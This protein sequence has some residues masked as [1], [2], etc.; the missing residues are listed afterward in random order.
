MNEFFTAEKLAKLTK[1]EMKYFRIMRAKSGVLF[2]KSKPGLAKSAIVKSIA[3]K[4]DMNFIDLRV[5]MMDEV[6]VGL[7][8]HVTD[9]EFQKQLANGELSTEKAMIKLL[10]FIVPKW[11]WK[12]NQRPTI[13]FFDEFNRGNL[14]VR[15]ACM[16]ILLERTIGS[17]FAFNRGVLMCTAGNM[18]DED[19]TQTEEF[20]SALNNRLIHVNHDLSPREWLEDFAYANVVSHI[21]EYIES[22]PDRLYPIS[23]KN[24]ENKGGDGKQS[25]DAHATPRSWT[26]LSDYIIENYGKEATLEQVTEA[27]T[28]VGPYY[29]GSSAHM[30]LQYL[31]DKAKLGIQDVLSNFPKIRKTLEA[32]YK[33]DKISQLVTDLKKIELESLKPKEVDNLIAFLEFMKGDDERQGFLMDGVVDKLPVNIKKA[34]L[35]EQDKYKNTHRISEH[36]KPLI[37]KALLSMQRASISN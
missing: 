33:R 8:P 3:T 17:E 19:G 30:F 28:E 37:E 16:Q 10:D 14:S 31:N 11:A 20:D 36:F 4:L 24:A 12:A 21:C 9:V 26:F 7:F 29:I 1:K 35:K 6:N 27:V 15:N 5:A 13:V 22:T 32:N 18:G 2:L 25:A 34:D 23:G